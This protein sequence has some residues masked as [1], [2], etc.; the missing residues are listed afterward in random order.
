MS[1]SCDIVIVGAGASGAAAA[2]S[3]SSKFDRI[4]C[5]EQG[6]WVDASKYPS[7]NTD[8]EIKKSREFSPLPNHR[9]LPSDYQIDDKDS[10]IAISNF[11]AVGGSTILYSGHFPRLHPSDFKTYTLDKVGYDW[12]INYYDLEKFYSI[13]DRE[14]GVSGLEG[15]PAYPLIEGM[16][17]PIDLGEIAKVIGS[18]FN[19]LG[20]H[21]W[22]SYAAILTKEKD[23]RGR[24]KNL[25][26][27]NTG[28]PQGAKASVD[29][30]YW[31]KAIK[32]GVELRTNSRV[33]RIKTNLRDEVEGVYF[34]DSK[35]KEKYLS[36][37]MVL[38]ACNGIGTPRILLN[39]RSHT[40]NET[41]AN[42]SDMVGRNLM[43][44][45]LGFIEG[46][47]DNE[48]NSHIGPH[49]C[50]ILSQEFYETSKDRSFKRGF[51]MQVLRGPGPIELAKS[52]IQRGLIPWGENHHQSFKKLHG[53]NVGISIICE[54]LPLESNRVTLHQELKDSNGIPCPKINYKLCD[55]TKKMMAFGLQKGKEV[56]EASGAR[57]I[58]TFGPVRNTG[59]HLMGTTKMGSDRETSV[60]NK[61]G[62]AH[63]VKNLFI[64]DSS[65]FPTGGAVN[66]TSSIQA[67]A[68]Y[69]SEN[70]KNGN[71]LNE[72]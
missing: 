63:D 46:I 42:R 70:I 24:C 3:L 32:N 67:V 45:P 37:K 30:T 48:M 17:P 20:W 59:W 10:P 28:C 6:D 66:P 1:D 47:F 44:H 55:N 27:C 38:M 36:C 25:G 26:P 54:D 9:N 72:S 13:N 7:T 11:N 22:P 15:D 64:I 43:L 51:T 31:P 12:P 60:V 4:I 52:G 18:G 57:D 41:L 8:W 14:M 2:W 49:G 53:R 34:Y 39:S 50:C 69:I 65:I 58:Y 16:L 23:G 19:K 29:I 61:Y 5:L 68:L 21:W 71:S 56:M 35:G 40:R 62:M 33:S